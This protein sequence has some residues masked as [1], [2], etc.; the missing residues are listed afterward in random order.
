MQVL[1]EA[2]AGLSVIPAD[3]LAKLDPEDYAVVIADPSQARQLAERL[4]AQ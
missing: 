4:A 1:A 3:L 2:C